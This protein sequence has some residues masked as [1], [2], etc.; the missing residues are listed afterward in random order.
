M[1]SPHNEHEW[2]RHYYLEGLAALS[3]SEST[4]TYQRG[5]FEALARN[6][7]KGPMN[8]EELEI[9]NMCGKLNRPYTNCASLIMRMRNPAKKTVAHD[10][11]VRRLC[12]GTDYSMRLFAV[13][14]D[15]ACKAAK[16]RA[17]FACGIRK[18][19]LHNLESQ[20]VAV[21][22]VVSCEVSADQSRP[23]TC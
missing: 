17:R 7:Q 9:T 12:T 15:A 13:D 21:F 18:M 20:G 19:D 23:V 22:R 3:R 11:T 2:T 14:A 1:P 5:V 8:R 4:Y 16:D 6:G 10:V